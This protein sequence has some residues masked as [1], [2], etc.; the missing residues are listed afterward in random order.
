MVRSAAV[1]DHLLLCDLSDAF[2]I[3]L[4]RGETSLHTTVAHKFK[5]YYNYNYYTIII[6]T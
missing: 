1:D 6:R 4:K 3:Y 2:R 5:F